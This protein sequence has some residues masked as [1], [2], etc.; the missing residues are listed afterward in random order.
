MLNL[1]LFRH[2]KSDWDAHYASDHERPLA[3][4]GKEAAKTMGRLLRRTGQM[5]ELAVSSSAIRARDTLHL[6]SRAGQWPSRLLIDRRLYGQSADAMLAWLQALRDDAQTL[7]LVGHEPTWSEFAGRLIGQ[8]TLRIPT[9]TM[10]RVD[11]QCDDWQ[12]VR[13]GTGELRWLLTPKL[14]AKLSK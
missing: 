14:V 10:L 2:G 13:F 9:A 7:L 5:P 12:E 4:R 8:A 1:I 6:A 3:S 11:C